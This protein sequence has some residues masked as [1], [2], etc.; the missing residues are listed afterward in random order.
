MV[1]TRLASL[2]LASGLGLISGCF[3]LADQIASWHC[4]P[5]GCGGGSCSPAASCCPPACSCCPPAGGCC[6]GGGFEAGYGYGYGVPVEGP[7]LQGGPIMN[8]PPP[9]PP[10][11]AAVPMPTVPPR[12]VPMPQ[13]VPVPYVPQVQ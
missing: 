7:A 2:A 4:C 3:N 6:N 9:P 10:A 11:E 8:V 12:L 13:S 1:R 5:L